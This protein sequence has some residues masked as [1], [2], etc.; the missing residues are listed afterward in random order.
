MQHIVKDVTRR[1]A[2]QF[3]A[4]AILFRGVDAWVL[5][6]AAIA[7]PL[8]ASLQYGWLSEL[9][10]AQQQQLRRRWDDAVARSAAAVN[11]DLSTFYAAIVTVAQGPSD[12]A[13]LEAAVD[14]WRQGADTLRMFAHAY[15]HERAT[16]RWIALN[17]P[18]ERAGVDEVDREPGVSTV[19]FAATWWP[20]ARQQALPAMAI[21]MDARA[22]FDAVV[23]MFGRDSCERLLLSLA[24]RYF[25]ST[26]N[27]SL[28]V[29][30][31]V[32]R[33]LPICADGSVNGGDDGDD[34]RAAIFQM[35]PGPMPLSSGAVAAP[36]GIG[37]VMARIAPLQ[38]GS[39]PPAPEAGM[40]LPRRCAESGLGICGSRQAWS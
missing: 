17:D 25:A 11:H 19:A 7:V 29:V 20:P 37:I 12:T 10:D 21:A 18:S 38:P 35:Q 33:G 22:T 32:P 24:Q 30:E 23:L 4:F 3:R 9:D 1:V 26:P 2:T 5:T 31:A 15:A 39:S 13:A 8:L 34:A 28:A 36:Q 14:A 16:A 6:A 40:R 27:V